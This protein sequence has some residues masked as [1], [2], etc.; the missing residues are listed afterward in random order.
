MKLSEVKTGQKIRLPEFRDGFFLTKEKKGFT[1]EYGNYIYIS[2][3]WR[4]LD[5]W[6]L[7]K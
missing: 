6:E 5:R 3:E 7:V 2:K 4:K 1:S